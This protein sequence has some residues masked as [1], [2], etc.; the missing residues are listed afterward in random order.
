VIQEAERLAGAGI[1]EVILVA[2]DTTAYGRDLRE[3]PSLSLLLRELAALS[4]LRWIRILY[5]HPASMTDEILETVAGEEKVCSYLDIPVQHAD[6]AVL[7]AMNRKGDSAAIRAAIRRAR[8]IIPGVTLR[9]SLIVGFPGETVKTFR[10]LLNFVRETRFENLG[11]FPYSEEEGTKAAALHP[12][13]SERTKLRRRGILMETQA[14]I[15]A[16]INQSRIGSI[17]E[18]LLEEESGQTEYP[19]L[20]RTRGQAPEID[21]LIYVKKGKGRIG[22]SILCRVTDADTYDLYAEEIETD[23]MSKL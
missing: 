12:R 4:A 5:A 9:T 13:L 17:E 21:G 15:S 16:E 22:E 14:V 7:R 6:D 18:V 19:V 20:G 23:G 11:V 10:T 2:Q 3:R 1:R 8:S